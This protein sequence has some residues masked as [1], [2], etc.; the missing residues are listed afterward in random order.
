[1]EGEEWLITDCAALMPRSWQSL[2]GSVF[3]THGDLMPV[4]SCRDPINTD[5]PLL[6]QGVRTGFSGPT[7]DVSLPTIE[8]GIDFKGEFGVIV[9][10]VPMGTCATDATNHVRLIAKINDCAL[11]AVAP[12]EMAIGFGW[13]P[14]KPF[15]RTARFALYILSKNQDTSYSSALWCCFAEHLGPV[16]KV[17][18]QTA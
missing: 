15:C 4:A 14:A 8:H 10:H 5:R 16:G 2:D 7:E 12:I 9:D 18:P 3:L 13:V 6:Y 17:D 1:M 11:R